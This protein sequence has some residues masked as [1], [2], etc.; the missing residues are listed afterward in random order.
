MSELPWNILVT[1]A[2]VLM[3]IGGYVFVI[4][5]NTKRIDSM[6][7]RIKEVESE[8]KESLELIRGKHDSLQLAIMQA[9]ADLK[10]DIRVLFDRLD[11]K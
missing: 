6:E 2:T 1:V 11:R 3:A 10:A 5:N 8:T 4:R 9:L 7:L